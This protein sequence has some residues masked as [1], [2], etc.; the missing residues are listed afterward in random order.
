MK[1]ESWLLRLYFTV[2]LPRAATYFP[3][4]FTM[5]EWFCSCSPCT[6]MGPFRT[7]EKSTDEN[8]EHFYLLFLSRCYDVYTDKAFHSTN[9]F[10][11]TLIKCSISWWLCFKRLIQISNCLAPNISKHNFQRVHFHS[12]ILKNGFY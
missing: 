12:L 4:R 5:I 3:N 1:T 7:S 6:Y 9:T 10:W 8:R 2:S 11:N